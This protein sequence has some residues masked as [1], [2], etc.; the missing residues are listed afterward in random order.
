M[1]QISNKKK[2]K[3]NYKI[4]FY[5]TIFF[6]KFFYKK[7]IQ[8]V[9]HGLPHTIKQDVMDVLL[10]FVLQNG[11]EMQLFTLQVILFK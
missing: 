10:Y 2:V 5:S 3:K 9:R 11:I 6:N 4:T 1:Q 8:K 7:K